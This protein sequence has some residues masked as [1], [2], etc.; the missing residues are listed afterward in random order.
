MTREDIISFLEKFHKPEELDPLHKWVGTYN[1]KREIVRQFFSWFYDPNTE[2]IRRKRPPIMENIPS[3]KR[4]EISI[5]KPTDLWTQTDDLLFLTYCPPKNVMV[6][7]RT[8]NGS[9]PPTNTLS[10]EKIG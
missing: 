10:K 2:R 8:K 6:Q 9:V 3:F 5:Y 1:I 4:K 7:I